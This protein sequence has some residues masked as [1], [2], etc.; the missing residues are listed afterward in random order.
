MIFCVFCD[1]LFALR[2]ILFGNVFFSFNMSCLFFSIVKLHAASLV[3]S[4]LWEISV[5]SGWF[6]VFIL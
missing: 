2:E 3:L 1:P 6:G 4:S 5:N